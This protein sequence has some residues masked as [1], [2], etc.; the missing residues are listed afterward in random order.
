MCALPPNTGATAGAGEAPGW[1]CC[2]Q[3]SSAPAF[4]IGCLD[5]RDAFFSSFCETLELLVT[6]ARFQRLQVPAHYPASLRSDC[7]QCKGQDGA[8]TTQQ[9][10]LEPAQA[11][12]AGGSA[13][14]ARW[15]WH[16]GWVQREHRAG[17]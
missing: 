13:D 7:C 3:H 9:R 1:R 12:Q 5:E 10:P 2:C 6:W 11:V 17:R 15:L 14:N 8:L 16:A 4:F